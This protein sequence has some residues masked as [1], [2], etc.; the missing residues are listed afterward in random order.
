M[1]P[2]M[3]VKV[4]YIIN[5]WCILITESVTVSNV[6]A[7]AS[8]V[9]DIWLATEI[10]PHTHTQRLGLSMLKFAK[11]LTTLQTMKATAGKAHLSLV[12][13]SW[14]GVGGITSPSPSLAH[15]AIRLDGLERATHLHPFEVFLGIISAATDFKASIGVFFC[16]PP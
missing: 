1:W 5:T 4:N 6:I 7:I 14:L 16:V 15:W 10:Q 8:L 13:G 2:W 11:L 12:M 9:S 3:K